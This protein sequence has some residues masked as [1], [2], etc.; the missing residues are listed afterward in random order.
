VKIRKLSVNGFRCLLEFCVDFDEELTVI[1]GEN[2]AGK[3]SLIECL[4]VITQGTVDERHM[5]RDM[6]KRTNN[7][8]QSTTSPGI[9]A[10]TSFDYAKNTWN[11]R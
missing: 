2:D 8:F 7:L 5:R 3:S 6:K 9:A 11:I 4:K 10:L 1:V